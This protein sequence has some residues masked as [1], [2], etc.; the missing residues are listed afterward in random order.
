[1]ARSIFRSAGLTTLPIVPLVA[2]RQEPVGGASCE[3][4]ACGELHLSEAAEH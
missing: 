4:G 2:E 3:E 1:M